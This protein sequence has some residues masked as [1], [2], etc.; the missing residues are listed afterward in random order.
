MTATGS[1]GGT[2]WCDASVPVVSSRGHPANEALRNQI[3]A[4]LRT[5]SD[6]KLKIAELEAHVTSIVQAWVKQ[7]AKGNAAE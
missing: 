2:D 4:F 5:A 1:S 7:E 3:V 6:G